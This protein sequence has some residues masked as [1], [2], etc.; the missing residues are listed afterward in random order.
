GRMEPKPLRFVLSAKGADGIGRNWCGSRDR[1]QGKTVGPSELESA[2]GLSVDPV[3]VFVHHTVVSAT[4]QGEVRKRRRATVRP[5]TDV[6]SLASRQA[7]T[8]E[9]AAAVTMMERPAQRW[10]KRSRPCPDFHNLPILVVSHDD[11]SR[12]AREAPG[13]FCRNARAAF[14]D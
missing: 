10:R 5:V 13:R 1:G 7:T 3:A 9:A 4:E 14:E 8:W 2:I 11:A 12:I 6:M